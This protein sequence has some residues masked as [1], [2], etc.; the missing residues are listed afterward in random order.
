V[1]TLGASGGY[2]IPLLTSPTF[3]TSLIVGGSATSTITGDGTDSQIGGNLFIGTPLSNGLFFG[4]GDGG[5]IAFDENLNTFTFE[6]KL[7]TTSTFSL[8]NNPGYYAFLDINSL[9]TDRAFTFPDISGSFILGTSTI[10][11][12]AKWTA[13]NTLQNAVAGTD[14]QSAITFPIPVA[15]TSLIAGTNL[16]LS[17][18]TLSVTSTPS[19]TTLAV[20]A[21]STFPLGIW[22][23]LGKVGI[24]TASPDSELTIVGASNGM[25]ELSIYDNS[26]TGAGFQIRYDDATGATYLDNRYNSAN[27][28]IY[29]RTRTAGTA[30]D[31]IFI[32]S[33]GNV[34]IGTASPGAKLDVNGNIYVTSTAVSGGASVFN[35]Q[36]EQ[37]ATASVAGAGWYRVAH[38]DGSSGRGQNTV[39]IYTTGGSY[40]PRSTTIRWWHNWNTVAAISAIS[41][42]GSTDYWSQARVT[43]D[44]T[45]SYLE[46][47][48]T[49]AITNL[50]IS[51]QYDGGYARGGLYSGA[52]SGGGDSV[53]ATA[54]L[55]FLTIGT[56]KFIIDSSGNVGI[57]TSTPSFQLH[58]A[59][60]NTTST[61]AVGSS[62]NSTKMG[63]VCLWNGT[64][65]T[66][67]KPAGADLATIVVTT[68]TTCN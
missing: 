17:T 27:G 12:L 2:S 13:L 32:E 19:F 63:V 39:T 34:G 46:V 40:E 7:T 47:Y 57:A 21:T 66:V 20:S 14:Y 52:L 11:S 55:G 56:N 54:T 33:A 41:E 5:T 64:S 65:Y 18:N 44:G 10:G 26:G 29:I 28:D 23:S 15:S 50:N 1:V 58:I 4:S 30:V 42:Y 53:R 6:S 60:N 45:N 16:V 38:I 48:F 35:V 22:N 59:A 36:K 31:G 67:Q 68:S 37:N 43:D 8:L 62:Y 49:Q 25:T 3:L 51:L 61:F 24:G 9:T